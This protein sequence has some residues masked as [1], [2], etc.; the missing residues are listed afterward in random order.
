MRRDHPAKINVI[1]V[2]ALTLMKELT[3]HLVSNTEKT[4]L[5][6]VKTDLTA[7]IEATNVVEKVIAA[8]MANE[9][10]E[11]EKAVE[12]AIGAMVTTVGVKDRRKLVAA[13]EVRAL[14]ALI[15]S[16]D[17]TASEV[18]GEAKAT[19][20]VHAVVSHCIAPST[21]ESKIDYIY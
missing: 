2:L 10:A 6:V 4:E 5:K 13:K 19:P 14:M 12:V 1:M 21:L 8:E 3:G 11:A 16:P 17:A 15:V 7:T 18:V 9:T 20:E